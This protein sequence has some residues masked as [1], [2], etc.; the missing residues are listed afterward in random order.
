MSLFWEIIQII[1]R[2][3]TTKMMEAITQAVIGITRAR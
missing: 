1:S 3:I 2:D